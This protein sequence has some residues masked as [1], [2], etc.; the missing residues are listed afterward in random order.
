MMSSWTRQ[1]QVRLGFRL[2]V[3]MRD[4]LL[5]SAVAGIA[6]GLTI[7]F[8]TLMARDEG[9]S[10][11]AIGIMASSYLVAQM[12]LQMPFG[13]LSDRIGRATPIALGFAVEGIASAGFVLADSAPAFIGLRVAQ[14]VA[15]ALIMPATRA[16]IADT[17]P[18]HQRGQ[19]YAWFIAC[20][21]GGLLLGPTI[22]G[23]L[24]GPLGRNP[25][26]LLSAVMNLSLIHI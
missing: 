25:L 7:P 17:T 13:A 22:G 5:L 4:V 10:L 11:R 23:A 8:L 24:A 6:F 3:I 18:L 20:F 19:A 9:V 1:V 16:L 12:L 14:G 26:F 21:S 2:P 15:L